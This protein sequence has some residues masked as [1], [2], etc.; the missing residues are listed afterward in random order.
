MK[1]N[2]P[3]PY[4]DEGGVT[5]YL[6]DC[7]KIV[8]TISADVLVA[9]PPYGMAYRSNRHGAPSSVKSAGGAYGKDWGVVAG[10]SKPF[11]PKFMLDLAL[12]SVIWVAN[13]FSSKLPD[14]G[15]W[16]VWDKKRGGTVSKDLDASDSELAWTNLRRT[17][18]TFSYLWDGFR[19]EGE[20]HQH[21]HPTQK[22]LALMRWVIEM[23][24]PG[25]VLDPYMGCGTTLVAAKALGR[26]AIG[27]E[28]EERYCEVAVQRLAQETLWGVA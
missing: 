9:D 26:K 24:P 12:P 7:T 14:S 28:I 11:D 21:F 23:C 8:P 25:T 6:G 15:G 1:V 17:I 16:L 20:I 5:I 27:V 3:T 22:P 13:W 19:R 2:Q 10:D 4:Y 18:K